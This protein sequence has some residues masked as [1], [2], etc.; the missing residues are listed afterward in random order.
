[1]WRKHLQYFGGNRDLFGS[2][3]PE[4]LK[5]ES[6]R[7]MGVKIC[8]EKGQIPAVPTLVDN[9]VSPPNQK[10][11][12]NEFFLI[13]QL[14]YPVDLTTPLCKNTTHLTFSR[15]SRR[16]SI[17]NASLINNLIFFSWNIKMHWIP[18]WKK[19]IRGLTNNET[20]IN[21]NITEPRVIFWKINGNQTASQHRPS[22]T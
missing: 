2:I 6:W 20:W 5:S 12:L 16:F 14:I 22:V 1:M 21:Q 19:L 17:I 11:Y 8:F 15:R 13:I 4:M 3:S 18:E 9:F 7:G 10:W